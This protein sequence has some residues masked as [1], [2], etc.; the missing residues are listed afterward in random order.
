LRKGT[1]TQRL[2]DFA[3]FQFLETG[4]KELKV[5]RQRH[6]PEQAV[7]LPGPI[8]LISPIS[9]RM[10]DSLAS[11]RSARMF[12][13]DVSPPGT[14]NPATSESDDGSVGHSLFGILEVGCNY[15]ALSC[16]SAPK[17]AIALLDKDDCRSMASR[18][19]LTNQDR[20]GS[21]CSATTHSHRESSEISTILNGAPSKT[22]PYATTP[23]TTVNTHD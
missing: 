15:I 19:A 7:N 6:R 23:L 21:P 11:K 2:P 4:S 18:P 3:K 14:T 9:L 10:T 22:T 12:G 17:H 13:S 8:S 16:A 1:F 5:A 20:S